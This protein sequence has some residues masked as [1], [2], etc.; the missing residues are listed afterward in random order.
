MYKL[1]KK[2]IRIYIYIYI[3][4]LTLYY[5]EHVYKHVCKDKYEYVKKYVRRHVTEKAT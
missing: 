5:C 4:N 2:I 1:D 3:H